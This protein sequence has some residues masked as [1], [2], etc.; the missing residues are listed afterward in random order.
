MSPF[1][2]L[3]LCQ[4]GSSNR[5]M[6]PFPSLAPRSSPSNS[7]SITL[8]ET[9]LCCQTQ[10]SHM[11]YRGSIS[12]TV[13]RRRGKVSGSLCVCVWIVVSERRRG[14]ES[15]QWTAAT[16]MCCFHNDHGVSCV[17]SH[18][19]WNKLSLLIFPLSSLRP[20]VFRCS[21]NFRAFAQFVLQRRAV[22]LQRAGSAAHPG[23]ME[24]SPH[25]Q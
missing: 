3:F 5:Q 25:G 10:H 2:S 11:T 9:G 15:A 14:R 16:E 7:P 19:K 6:D 1:P 13:L 21:C 23:A 24:T 12:T 22:H 8:T 18:V 20:A 4:V 17:E